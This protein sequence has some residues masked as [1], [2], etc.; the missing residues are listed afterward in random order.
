MTASRFMRGASQL[1]DTARRRRRERTS[2]SRWLRRMALLAEA[3]SST[4]V[5][6]TNP[7]TSAP[8][9]PA[10]QNTSATSQPWLQAAGAA[11]A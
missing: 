4:K 7:A 5:A 3:C 1:S 11:R 10:T 2:P 8:A 6:T 9:P